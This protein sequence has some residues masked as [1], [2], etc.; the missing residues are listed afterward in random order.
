[1]NRRIIITGANNGIGLAMTHAL[2]AMGDRVAGLDLDTGS[3]A[4]S[5]PNLLA[6]STCTFLLIH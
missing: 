4:I 6:V 1:M 3:L 5:N 2:L